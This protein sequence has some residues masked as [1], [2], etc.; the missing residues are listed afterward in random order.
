MALS[1]VSQWWTVAGDGGGFGNVIDV[2]ENVNLGFCFK[3]DDE[4]G[5]W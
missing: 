2:F 4:M 3:E 5:R 1:A